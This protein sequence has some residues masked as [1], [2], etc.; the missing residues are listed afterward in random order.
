[1]AALIHNPLACSTRKDVSVQLIQA[2]SN[3]PWCFR[4]P[5]L[6]FKVCVGSIDGLAILISGFIFG[7]GP[8]QREY[9]AG[10][11]PG[12]IS[13]LY[14]CINNILLALFLVSYLRILRVIRTV[15]RA[16]F[17]Y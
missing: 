11:G 9:D 6:R 10:S 7:R 1:M 12:R 13:V 2:L 3:T 4:L 15:G 8:S 17:F 16:L 5:V 14:N